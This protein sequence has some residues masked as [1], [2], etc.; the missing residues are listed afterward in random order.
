MGT[1]KSSVGQM[2]AAQLRFTYLDTDHVIEARAGKSINEIFSQQGE[3]VFRELERRIVLELEQR[4][5]TVISTG[6]GLPVNDLNLASLKSHAF[7]VCLWA[8]PEKIWERV[9]DQTHRPL[10]NEPDPPAKIRQ[11]LDLRKPFYR[12]ADVLLNTEMRSVREVAQQVIHQFN[13]VRAAHR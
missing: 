10:L 6:G 9:R 1:G 12:Q 7:V 13:M 11:L 5:R 2:V 3:P 8:S 4:T